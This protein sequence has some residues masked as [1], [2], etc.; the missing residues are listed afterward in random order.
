MPSIRKAD[1]TIRQPITEAGISRMESGVSLLSE[2]ISSISVDEG[3]AID[4]DDFSRQIV[5]L[6]GGDELHDDRDIVRGSDT[7]QRNPARYHLLALLSDH[8]G[9]ER[10]FDESRTDGIDG[11][12]R[13][14]FL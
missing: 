14:E 5:R 10:G 1:M 13:S 2:V 11:H 7:T 9:R 6:D 3:A 4:V 8:V 12:V